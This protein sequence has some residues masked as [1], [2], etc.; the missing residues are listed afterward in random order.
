MRDAGKE[1]EMA[2]INLGKAGGITEKAMYGTSTALNYLLKDSAREL[3]EFINAQLRFAGFDTNVPDNG[4]EGP[5]AT[6]S[7]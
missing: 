5:Q 6:A 4:T 1:L 3:A 7:K 2:L